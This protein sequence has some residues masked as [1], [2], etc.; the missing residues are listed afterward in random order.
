MASDTRSMCSR[1]ATVA[2][3]FSW[4]TSIILRTS[5]SLP[6]SPSRLSF[7]IWSISAPLSSFF[8]KRTRRTTKPMAS[9]PMAP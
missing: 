6:A 3:E 4:I 8:Q 7:S 1:M 5:S 2:S 9:T